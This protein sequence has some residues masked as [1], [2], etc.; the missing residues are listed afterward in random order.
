MKI[1][2][3]VGGLASILGFALAVYMLCYN[4]PRNRQR[5]QVI[6]ETVEAI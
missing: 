3:V 2:N 6:H 5:L 4:E 1:V